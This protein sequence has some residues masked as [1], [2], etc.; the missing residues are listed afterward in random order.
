[1]HGEEGVFIVWGIGRPHQDERRRCHRKVIIVV[2]QRLR[3]EGASWEEEE[4]ALE[5]GGDF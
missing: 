5:K 3:W 1:M 4:E 2:V